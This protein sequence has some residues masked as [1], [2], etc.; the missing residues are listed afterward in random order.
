[1]ARHTHMNEGYSNYHHQ[2]VYEP[3]QLVN[4]YVVE[5]TTVKRAQ[6][7]TAGFIKYGGAP[8]RHEP[9]REYVPKYAHMDQHEGYELNHGSSYE[10]SSMPR[11]HEVENH[12]ANFLNKVQIEASRTK[13]NHM[14]TSPNKYR[15]TSPDKY[16]H[17]SL[18][19]NYPS[20]ETHMFWAQTLPSPN[21]GQ[22]TS[23]TKYRPTTHRPSVEPANYSTWSGSKG[24]GV[25]NV[26]H[27]AQSFKHES[28]Y[29]R[30]A[31]RSSTTISYSR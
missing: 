6:V 2:H 13:N 18:P 1:M 28:S 12:M 26:V 24:L 3:E 7:P 11:Y 31:F 21:K 20:E 22:P 30:H 16:Q 14:L 17:T 9:L 8:L 4:W 10:N 27:R 25:D 29:T 19:H 15:P 5:T 23:S